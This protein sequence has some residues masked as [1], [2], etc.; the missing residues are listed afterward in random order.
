M[1]LRIKKSFPYGGQ[2]KQPGEIISVP[3]KQAKVLVAIGKAEYVPPDT[4]SV[5]MN[6]NVDENLNVEVEQSLVDDEITVTVKEKEEQAKKKT[7]TSRTYKRRDMTAE[8]GKES[9]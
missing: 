9:K 8:G 1:K 5:E 4:E 3:A 2:R 6:V 7:T